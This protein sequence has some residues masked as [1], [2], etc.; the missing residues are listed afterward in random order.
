MQ[1]LTEIPRALGIPDDAIESALVSTFVDPSANNPFAD[2]VAD[3]GLSEDPDYVNMLA[4]LVNGGNNGG[5]GPPPPSNGQDQGQMDQQ[6]QTYPDG[7][8]KREMDSADMDGGQVHKRG[9][10]SDVI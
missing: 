8:R 10:Y 4:S 7:Y 6:Q 1:Q 9:R 5:P 3:F 2:M